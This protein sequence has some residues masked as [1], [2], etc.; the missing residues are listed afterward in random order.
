[1]AP[2]RCFLDPKYVGSDFFSDLSG[3]GGIR[4]IGKLFWDQRKFRKGGIGVLIMETSEVVHFD[5]WLV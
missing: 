5:N 4:P 2:K 3:K 1:M